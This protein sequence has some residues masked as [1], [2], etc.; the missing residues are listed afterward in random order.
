MDEIRFLSE[1]EIEFLKDN[2]NKGIEIAEI[3]EKLN[4]PIQNIKIK[5]IQ[6][7][8]VNPTKIVVT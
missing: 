8:L 1:K 5:L 4:R 3:A 2:Y 6:I 7:G